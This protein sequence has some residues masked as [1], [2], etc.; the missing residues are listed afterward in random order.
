LIS[1]QLSQRHLSLGESAIVKFGRSVVV[2]ALIVTA[3]STNTAVTVEVS[4]HSPDPAN[5]SRPSDT[6]GP[7]DIPQP[8]NITRPTVTPTPSSPAGIETNPT[9]V[10]D[11]DLATVTQIIDGYTID[12]AIGGTTY[13]VRYTGMDTPAGK[14]LASA[15]AN[16][17]ALRELM[18]LKLSVGIYRGL[19]GECQ[20]I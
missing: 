9:T 17:W 2:E 18:K 11:G 4:S 5:T 12:V 16:D 8:T 14:S 10:P 7:T 6:A 1:Y 15:N 19:A 20:T 13:R 3:E